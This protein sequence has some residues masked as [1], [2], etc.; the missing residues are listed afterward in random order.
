MTDIVID[1]DGVTDRPGLMDRFADGLNLPD[2]FGR[3]W[4]ALADVLRDVPEGR[5]VVVRDWRA[6]A[7]ARPEEWEIALDVLQEAD[8]PVVLAL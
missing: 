2:W 5:R 8:L 7:K 1:L 4:D 6:Y 3:N